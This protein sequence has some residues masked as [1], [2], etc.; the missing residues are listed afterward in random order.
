VIVQ[1]FRVQHICDKDTGRMEWYPSFSAATSYS[2][3]TKHVSEYRGQDGC[4]VATKFF[5][6]LPE[7][8]R[9]WLPHCSLQRSS[10]WE[11][12]L[13]EQQELADRQQIDLWESMW[14]SIAAMA[15][16]EDQCFSFFKC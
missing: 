15:S 10:R 13:E 5:L 14:W 8:S 9:Q 2:H 4:A 12:G 11:Q 6:V 1:K 16:V 3:E 7:N